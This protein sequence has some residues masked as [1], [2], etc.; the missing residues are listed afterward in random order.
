LMAFY[1]YKDLLGEPL[2]IPTPFLLSL[3]ISYAVGIFIGML[4]AIRSGKATLIFAAPFMPLYW[5]MLCAPT[6]RALWELY[7][8]PFLWHKTEHGVKPRAT[9]AMNVENRPEPYELIG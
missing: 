2:N 1:L 4:G 9:L 5:L 6:L 7:R 8:A 3:G